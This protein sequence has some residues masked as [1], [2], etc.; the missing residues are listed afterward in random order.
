MDPWKSSLDILH[1]SHLL[2]A[3][4]DS[5]QVPAPDQPDL[6]NVET[7]SIPTHLMPVSFHPFSKLGGSSCRE[8]KR[9]SDGAICFC[10][11][12]TSS[13]RNVKIW[14]KKPFAGNTISSSPFV[15]HP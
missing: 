2:M 15:V 11:T 7:L 10:T 3:F 14:K 12:I 1:Q 6:V 8:L 5:V 4:T 9:V 13:A